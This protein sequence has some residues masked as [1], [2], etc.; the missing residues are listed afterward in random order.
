VAAGAS[1]ANWRLMEMPR[2]TDVRGNLTAIEGNKEVPFAIA[3]VYYLY[4]VPSGSTRAAHAHKTLHQVFLPLA[5]SFH[6]HLD[7]AR[8]RT[9]F[10]LNR[11]NIGLYVRPGVW[12]LID[13]FSA[14]SVCLVLASAPY[15]EADY[16][17][18][19]DEFRE[20]VYRRG[21]GA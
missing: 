18:S 20:F 14:G 16:I 7:D 15:A 21:A 17:R 9:S 19:Y 3:R 5:G 12:R 10:R 13:D 6:V 1:A 8:Q 11:P 4:D 2:I